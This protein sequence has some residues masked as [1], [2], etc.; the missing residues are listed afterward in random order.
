MVF[1]LDFRKAFNSVSWLALDKILKTRGVSPI[2]RGWINNTLSTGKMI[3]L[4]NG[5]S[6]NWID[7]KNG[8]RQGGPL[9]PYLFLIVADLLQ[10][11]II[12]SGD[13]L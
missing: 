6:G 10:Q 7:R 13:F 3:I 1:K 9:S 12:H 2:F 5:V 8:L 11:L 4:L